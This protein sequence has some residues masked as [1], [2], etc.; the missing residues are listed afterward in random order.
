[1]A[2]VCVID[3]NSGKLPTKVERLRMPSAGEGVDDEAKQS[4]PTRPVITLTDAAFLL[5]LGLLVIVLARSFPNM[6]I[7]VT[8]ADGCFAQVWRNPVTGQ[9]KA[10]GRSRLGRDGAPLC[11]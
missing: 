10:I 7:R 11:R 5:M 6:G 2:S 9:D 4:C 1:M 8:G 3:R